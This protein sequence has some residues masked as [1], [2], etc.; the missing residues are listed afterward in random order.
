[1]VRN[2]CL[3]LQKFTKTGDVPF[4][5]PTQS[6]YALNSSLKESRDSIEVQKLFQKRRDNLIYS[7]SKIGIECLNENPS[8]SIIAFQHPTKT[9]EQLSDFL[10]KMGLLYTLELREKETVLE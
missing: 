6:V 2:Y 7:F 8:N 5:L 4:T 9:Y 10:Y 3:N 1:M